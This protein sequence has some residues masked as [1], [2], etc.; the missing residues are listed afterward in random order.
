MRLLPELKNW[1]DEASIRPEVRDAVAGIYTELATET[2]RRRPLCIVSG[3]C[4]RFEEFGH[5]LFVTTMELADFVHQY[6]AR[7]HPSPPPVYQGRG[8]SPTPWDGTGC[9]F[10]INKLCGVHALRPMGC[11]IFFC[12]A[13][14]AQWQQDLYE[15]LHARLKSLHETLHVPYAY[16]EWRQALTALGLA[17][18]QIPNPGADINVESF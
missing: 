10:Q 9:P 12:D 8:T 3:R 2:D 13:S 17:E 16:V 4:C 5:R 14:S 7:P 11:R 6:N 1:V 18:K 15:R